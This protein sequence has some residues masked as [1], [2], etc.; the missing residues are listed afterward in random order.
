MRVLLVIFDGLADRRWPVLGGRTPLEAANTPNMDKLAEAG[1]TGLMHPLGRG[2]AP[3]SELAHFALFG[4][5][6]DLYPGRGVF[7]AL[8]HGLELEEGDV[9]VHLL[10]SSVERANGLLLVKE[11][12]VIA[13]DETC[14]EL[15]KAIP[16]LEFEGLK[17]KSLFTKSSQGMLLIKG[18]ASKDITDSDPY[19]LER[20]VSSV[21]PV[22]SRGDIQIAEKTARA[23]SAFLTSA[24]Q[25]MDGHPINERRRMSGE[26]PIN[27][28][29]TKWAGK[30][31]PIPS[32][33]EI[34]GFKA[35][36]ICSYPLYKGLARFLGMTV[37]DV[38]KSADP[39]EDL[40]KRLKAAERAFAEGFEFLHVHSKAP[41]DAGHEKDPMKKKAVLENLDMAL[42]YL[43]ESSLIN[44]DNLIVLTGD[45]A[46]PSGTRLLHS[47]DP[48]PI[49][50][51]GKN[52][53]GDGV[54]SFGESACLFGGLGQFS[55]LDLM[56]TL[57][58]FTDRIR[59]LG[60]SL[61]PKPALYE[62]KRLPPFIVD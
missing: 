24:Y 57:L 36:S 3:S 32:F 59:Y 46:T 11:R 16:E 52:A 4:Y 15:M 33:E 61:T 49:L 18:G 9:A 12:P 7:E 60:A 55:G 13:P 34:A 29:L 6:L 17:L 30:F 48:V 42:G 31:G 28:A 51:V 19:Y 47:G 56:P 35:V 10:L 41:D 22:Q 40:L 14:E 25:A 1:L 37:I 21:Q 23:V 2:L 26:R 58:N 38:C 27:F 39:K 43:F 62:P 53:W 50:M 54:S 45:H 20:P 8:G 5:P 44:D